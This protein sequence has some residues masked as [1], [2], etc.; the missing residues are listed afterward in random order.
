MSKPTRS[1]SRAWRLCTVM[2]FRPMLHLLIRNR[3]EGMENIPKTG[4][5]IFAPSH[6][7]YA[8]W[9][10]DALFCY[11][12]GRFPTFLI[13]ASAFK[14]PVIGK[15]LTK[16]G[17]LP[18]HRGRADAALVLK[19]AEEELRNGATVIIYP[20]GTATR[21]P[22]MWPMVA[23]TG[24]ARLALSSGCPV[25]PIAHWG[26]HEVLPYGTKNLK[27]FP[28]RTVRTKAGPPVDLSA[29]EGKHTSAKA[30][31][32]ATEKVMSDVTALLGELRGATPPAAP[33]DPSSAAI[34]GGASPAEAETS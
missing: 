11:E 19:Q 6:I 22:D 5:V 34:T 10:V 26:T 16:D 31:R 17:Q 20:E 15:L 25:I 7:S 2:L 27:V 32:E 12:S 24:V 30:L 18:V 3:W 23:K 21:D 29:W 8:D 4:G 28:R 1:Y 13:K 14:V 33:Y 9:G